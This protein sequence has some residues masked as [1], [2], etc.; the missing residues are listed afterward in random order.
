MKD[1]TDSGVNKATD[2]PYFE[3]DF[4]TSTMEDLIKELGYR[5]RRSTKI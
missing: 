1:C 4:W 3:G 5:R 2:I